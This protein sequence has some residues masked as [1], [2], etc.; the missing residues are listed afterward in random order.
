MAY[1]GYGISTSYNNVRTEDVINNSVNINSNLD[2]LG[3]SYSLAQMDLIR[4]D[5][6]AEITAQAALIQDL[7]AFVDEQSVLIDELRQFVIALQTQP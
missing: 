6:G 5:L 3:A 4:S 1:F 7:T 2:V